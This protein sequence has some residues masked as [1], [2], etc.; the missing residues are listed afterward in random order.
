MRKLI[1]GLI[2]KKKHNIDF[3]LVP[4]AI[5]VIEFSVFITQLSSEPNINFGNLI[6]LR[7]I[8]TIAMITISSLVSQLYRVLKKPALSYQTLAITAILVLIPGDII[9]AF[10]ASVFEIE[11]VSI[12]RRIGIILIQGFFWFPAIMIVLGY[13]REIIEQ[14]KV[15][16]QR[17]I[18][19]TRLRSRT[20][21]EFKT[22][23]KEIQIRIRGELYELCS[24]L[25]DSLTTV[26]N[27]SVTLLE[28]NLYTRAILAGEDLRKFSRRLESFQDIKSR[29]LLNSKDQRSL[30][31]LAQQFR[32]LYATAV[33]KA[34][35]G[36][37]AYVTVLIALATPPFFYFHS[38]RELLFSIPILVIFIFISASIIRRIQRIDSTRARILSSALIFLSGGLPFAIDSTWQIINPD[39]Q[40]QVPLLVTAV[41]LPLTYYLFMEV[42]Q[43]LRPR[44]LRLIENNDLR[45]GKALQNQVT[46]TVT[47]EFSHNLSHQWAVFIHGKILT[48]LAAT[49]LKLETLAKQENSKAFDET[50]DTLESLLADP[51]AQFDETP[52]DLQAEVN[53]RLEPWQGLLEINLFIDPALQ[54]VKNSRVRDL[55]EVMEELLSNSIRH[56]KAKKID[57]KLVPSAKNEIEII[58]TDDSTDEPPAKSQNAGL[59]T[60]IFN[61]ASDGRWSITRHNSA[62]EF[63]LTMAM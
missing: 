37:W 58:S 59:G 53:A 26:R 42:F 34:P 46:K 49:A 20:S 32:V 13:R 8:H 16:G 2:L 62:T 39:P 54:S 52:R 61:L 9:H 47:A 57:L 7:V 5:I 24:A 45:A 38:F 12:Y 18:T 51:A 23:G 10:F 4:L 11:L 60:R 28:R 30:I 31:L 29:P 19:E 36:I 15:Y 21:E 55:G 50:L 27:S 63:R 48:R 17:L 33:L 35:L 40:V 1:P 6:L 43:V 44:A 56:G 14:F 41:A 3:S 25:K 22:L